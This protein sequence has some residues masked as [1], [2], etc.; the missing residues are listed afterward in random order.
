MWM[1][2]AKPQPKLG[3]DAAHMAVE[4][5]LCDAMGKETARQQWGLTRL[6]EQLA[7]RD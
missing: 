7:A 6:L 3:I 1:T 4:V 2:S 5:V